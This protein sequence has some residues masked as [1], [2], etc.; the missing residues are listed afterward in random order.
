MSQTDPKTDA[1]REREERYLQARKKAEDERTALL[2]RLDDENADDLVKRLSKCGE[3]FRLVCTGCGTVRDCR[4]RC[5]IKWCPACSRALATRTVEKYR[6]LVE[7]ATWPLFVTLTTKNYDE[8]SVRPLRKAWGKL[9]RLRWF[10]RCVL[11]GVAGFEMTNTGKGWHW[12]IHALLDC[13]WF[14]VSAEKP[15]R[16]AP[17]DLWKAR[18][19]TAAKEVGEQWTLCTGRPSSVKVRRVWTCD[20]GDVTKACMEVL[21]YSVTAA[22]LLE[23]PEPIAPALRLMDGTRLVTSFGTFFGKGTKRKKNAPQVCPCGCSERI[24]EHLVPTIRERPAR[25]V[26]FR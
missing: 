10:R 18:G 6:S 21:K 13:E 3:L 19:K 25:S 4:T 26:T 23:S 14:A 11:G 17:A 16:N 7:E 15:A 9:R 24:P 1:E 22:S 20:D 5:D 8:P 2:A 12:H